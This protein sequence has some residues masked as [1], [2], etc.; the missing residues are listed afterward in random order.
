MRLRRGNP[1]SSTVRVFGGVRKPFL[2]SKRRSTNDF[3][4]YGENGEHT[5]VRKCRRFGY[6]PRYSKWVPDERHWNHTH[7]KEIFRLRHTNSGATEPNRNQR[8][9][10]DVKR[11]IH[12]VL[13]SIDKGYMI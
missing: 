4:V 12:D 3:K 11:Y 6:P 5:K 13:F 10:Y 9:T 8:F 7:R 2:I 1:A